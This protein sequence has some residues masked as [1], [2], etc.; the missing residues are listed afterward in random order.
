M[1]QVSGQERS[2]SRVARPGDGLALGCLGGLVAGVF[3]LVNA[4]APLLAPTVPFTD[5]LAVALAALGLA[6]VLGALAGAFFGSL[7]LLGSQEGRYLPGALAVSLV[8]AV[9]A[10]ALN[11]PLARRL[12]LAGWVALA[13]ATIA[14]MAAVA[15]VVRLRRAH[16]GAWLLPLAFGLALGI[17]GANAALVP[18]L[19]RPQHATLALATV[20][21]LL[22]ASSVASARAPWLLRVGR[23]ALPLAGAAAVA[24]LAGWPVAP[25]A[26]ARLLLERDTLVATHAVDLVAAFTDWDA[27]GFTSLLGGADCEPFDARVRPGAPDVPDDALDQDCLGGP[28]T[29]ADQAALQA[30]R[31]TL[32]DRE[33]PPVRA[34]PLIVLSVDALRADRALGMTGV[35]HLAARGVSFSRAYVAYPSTILSF[36]SL[37]TGRAPSA[38]ATE[39]VLKWDVP[40]PDRSQTLPEALAAAGYTTA[41]LFFHHLFG[42][43]Y[44]LTR[45]FERVWVES[46][47]PQVVVWGVSSL[48]TA[49]RA[50]AALDELKHEGRPFFLWVHFYDPHE[51][52][53]QHPEEPV[54]DPGS[55]G[56]LYDG[57]VRFTD[58]HLTRLV[59]HLITDG[60]TDRALVV[61]LSDH[62][63]S[64]GEGGRLFH[65]S[66]LTEEQL[67]VPLVVVGPGVPKGEKRATPVS[68]QDLA[69]TLTEELGLPRLRDSQGASF[70]RL[71]R[72]PD[73]PPEA[74]TPPVFFEVF[75]DAGVQR[76]VLQ[77]PWK[78]VQHVS[79]GALE[80]TDVTRDP[81]EL[82][83]VVDLAPQVAARL[84]KLLSTWGAATGGP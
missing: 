38:V 14:L 8:A 18:G 20:G 75:A 17:S 57:E 60:W 25:G 22:L 66:A 30:S 44:G 3:D 40:R 10:W 15:L 54:D 74:P 80:L 49:D 81:N 26:N 51:P 41:G 45:G 53:V 48:Q 62:G 58:R 12:G 29:S 46:S 24:A 76:G 1:D 13:A 33:T 9:P 42:P 71:L 73:P 59:E 82:L 11:L 52:Y 72:H 7:V 35:R 37:F 5:A 61:L 69:D 43:T 56:A 67:R 4:R 19:Y 79:T 36:Y 27:D 16:R 39:R 70:R 50:L 84:A 47:D 64:L 23:G 34:R 55:Y 83:N 65:N 31:A 63:E 32:G 6:G 68:L 28:A 2:T 77:G 78:L 21:L